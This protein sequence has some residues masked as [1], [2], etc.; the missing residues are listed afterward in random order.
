VRE[1]ARGIAA[2]EKPLEAKKRDLQPKAKKYDYP[3]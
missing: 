3:I 1:A 2:R